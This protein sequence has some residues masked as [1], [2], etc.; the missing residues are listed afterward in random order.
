MLS[1]DTSQQAF[2]KDCAPK[3]AKNLGNTCYM[4]AILQALLC[5]K[6]LQ[7]FFLSGP[8]PEP[9]PLSNSAD[10]KKAWLTYNILRNLVSSPGTLA[11]CLDGHLVNQRLPHATEVQISRV[12]V[13]TMPR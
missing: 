9:V 6:Q 10:S 7:N 3:G 5:C 13:Q 11:N 8:V 12:L 4:N 2:A 1:E